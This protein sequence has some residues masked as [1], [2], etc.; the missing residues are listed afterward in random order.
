MWELL[1]NGWKRRGSE[2]LYFY[3]NFVSLRAG[4]STWVPRRFW[5]HRVLQKNHKLHVLGMFQG[6]HGF[7]VLGR[8][9]YYALRGHGSCPVG[10]DMNLAQWVSMDLAHPAGSYQ[11]EWTWILGSW[12]GSSGGSLC[13][14]QMKYA[15]HS[16]ITRL[17]HNREQEQNNNN[18]TMCEFQMKLKH[19]VGLV[20]PGYASHYPINR[21]AHQ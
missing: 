3:E 15:Q 11:N 14:F 8:D 2:A 6:R 12:G 21:H 18:I 9:W 13:K 19:W 1:R 10:G 4:A 16:G 17:L 5:K 7:S 20:P